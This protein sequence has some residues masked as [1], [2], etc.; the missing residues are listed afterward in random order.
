MKLIKH[1]IEKYIGANMKSERYPCRGQPSSIHIREAILL[2]PG[3][4]YLTDEIKLAQS[5]SMISHRCNEYR[6]LHACI[7]EKTSKLFAS[8]TSFIITGSGTAGNEAALA[9]MLSKKDK[10]ICFSNGT[11]GRRFA[12]AAR[13]YSDNVSEKKFESGKGIN[14]DRTKG[15]IDDTRADVLAIVYNESSTGV[16]NKIRDICRYAKRKGIYVIVDG[17][18]AVG[19]CEMSMRDWGIDISVTCSQ[20][21][22]GAPPG[23]ALIGVMDSALEKIEKN[24]VRSFYFDLKRYKKYQE[25]NETPFTPAVSV[26]F[27]LY[28]ALKLLEKEGLDARIERHRKASEY[29]RAGLEKMGFELFAEKGF[30]S[31]AVTTFKTDKADFIR[32][33]LKAKYDIDINS[34]MEEMKG[35]ILRI[36]HVGNFKQSDLDA[37]LP[38]IREIDGRARRLS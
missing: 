29:L 21:C 18:S 6:E 26:M 14:L 8:D 13:I 16:A 11:F 31:N 35:K 28:E 38:A 15:E 33:E 12:E 7:C 23:V 20:K 36:G 5:T 30:E 25:K 17:V 3:P 4:A 9:S 1:N 10:V 34:G 27:G 2:T 19:G 24:N 32:K 22:L 37:C